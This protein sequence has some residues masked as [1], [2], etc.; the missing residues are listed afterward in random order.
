M[1]DSKGEIEGAGDK[2]PNLTV[3]ALGISVELQYA[4]GR[5]MVFQTHTEQAAS[6]DA[7]NALLDKMNAAADRAEAYYAQEQARRQLEVEEN[8]AANIAKRLSEVEA[9]I[10]IK[11]VAEGGRRNPQLS[12]KESMDKK[13]ALDSVEESRR[14]VATCREHLADLIKK[15]GN[16]DGASG[17]ANS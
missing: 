16:R 2:Q 14:R 3:P 9:N 15:A 13:Q 5:K 4:G 8:A 1:S 11:S 12:A 17:P 6:L 10:Q 7:L